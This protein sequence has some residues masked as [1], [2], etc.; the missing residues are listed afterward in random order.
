MK[1]LA[2]PSR[3]EILQLLQDQELP[4]TDIQFMLDLPQA[5][6]SQHLMILREAGV[7]TPRR[8]GKQMYYKV[9][10]PKLT[11]I[12][13]LSR[14]CVLEKTDADQEAS[15]EE[16]AVARDFLSL[17]PLTHDPI[18]GMQLSPKTASYFYDHK[19]R[20]HYFCASGCLKVFTKDPQ[21][22]ARD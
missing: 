19:G 7:V 11:S 17:L 20:R 22:Y 15:S 12:N 5:N 4:V 9:A 2:H 21:A 3:L 10:D 14:Q 16:R 8:D 18:C 6:I 1:A 13:L